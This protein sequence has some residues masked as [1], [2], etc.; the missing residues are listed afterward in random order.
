MTV[1]RHDSKGFPFHSFSAA[2]LVRSTRRGARFA[3]GLGILRLWGA[4]LLTF[5]LTAASASADVSATFTQG[6]VAEYS[7]SNANQNDDATTFSTLSI[8]SVVMS[9]PYA[10]WGDGGTQGNDEDVTLTINFSNGN[11]TVV[12]SGALNWVKNSPGGGIVYFGIIFTDSSFN[13]GFTLSA[14]TKKKTYILPL[15]GF[16]ANLSGLVASDGTDGSANFGANELAALAA[17]LTVSFPPANNAPAFTATNATDGGGNASYSFDYPEGSATTDVLGTVS[18]TDAD[19][20][21]LSF[22]ITGGNGDGFYALDA[23]T[24]EITLTPAGAASLANDFET[25]ANS[26]TLTVEVDDGGTQVTIEVALNETNISDTAPEFTA[27]NAT[28]GGGNASYSFD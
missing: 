28:D 21:A 2:A 5:L 19:G 3:L 7:N 8:S 27:T 16:E 12:V 11:P 24:G 22:A 6:V 18:A 9:Q 17:A 26:R 23:T 4:F 25:T 14:P 1:A 15:P 13:D 20:D 10:A